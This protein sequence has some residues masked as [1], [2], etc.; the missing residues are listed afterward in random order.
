VAGFEPADILL[1]I[2]MLIDQVEDGRAA[3]ENAYPR[4]VTEAGNTKAKA[5]M[6]QVFEPV[7]AIWRGLGQIPASGL[8]FRN[9]FQGHDAAAVLRPDPGNVKEPAACACGDV[10][11]GIKTPLGCKLYGTACTPIHPV[12]PCMVSSEG[13]CAAYYRYHPGN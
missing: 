1:A 13:T 2:A 4:A 11:K 6:Q 12:G 8:G 9:P 3:L 10:L 7:D 5:L